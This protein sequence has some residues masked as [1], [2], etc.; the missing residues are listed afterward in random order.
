M[1]SVFFDESDPRFYVA[2]SAVQGA[3]RG[4]FATTS[5]SVGERLSV[6]GVLVPAGSASDSCT[7]YADHYKF[8]VDGRLLIPVGFG[9]LVNHSLAPNLQKVIEGDQ[10]F[11]EVIKPVQR[12]E[13]L[14][15]TYSAFAQEKFGLL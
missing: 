8:R 6:I 13:E 4:L 3:G 7:A 9:G 15:F 1:T 14:F 11:L 10:V 2:E 12:G 5:L